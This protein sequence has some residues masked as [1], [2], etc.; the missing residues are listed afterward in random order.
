MF[1]VFS[2]ITMYVYIICIYMDIYI[3]TCIYIYIS[4]CTYLCI[5]DINDSKDDKQK[6]LLKV[7]TAKFTHDHLQTGQYRT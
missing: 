6:N 7:V 1:L 4:V 2:L 5:D 3:F